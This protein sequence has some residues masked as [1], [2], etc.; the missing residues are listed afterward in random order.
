MP[1]A[2]DF[3]IVHISSYRQSFRNNRP[4]VTLREQPEEDPFEL[5]ERLRSNLAMAEENFEL[6]GKRNGSTVLPNSVGI[7]LR[8]E[9]VFPIKFNV[10]NL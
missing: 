3:I 9:S 10:E 4:K 2:N 1:F 8:E 7:L 5:A 6:G